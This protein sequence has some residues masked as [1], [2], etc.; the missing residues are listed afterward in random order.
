MAGE[1]TAEEPRLTGGISERGVRGTD[2]PFSLCDTL[3][4]RVVEALWEEKHGCRDD[5]YPC[6]ARGA[7]V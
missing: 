4:C 5:H 3:R 6:A 2:L 1:V 7:N